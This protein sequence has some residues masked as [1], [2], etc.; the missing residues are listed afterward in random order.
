MRTAGYARSWQRS[1]NRTALRRDE[2]EQLE[3]QD[4][5]PD[6]GRGDREDGADGELGGTRLREPEALDVPRDRGDCRRHASLIG[7]AGGQLCKRDAKGDMCDM[8]AASP[9]PLV[10]RVDSG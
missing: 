8:G 5:E 7:S 6:P 9:L 2:L 3:R 1:E 4:E 10:T